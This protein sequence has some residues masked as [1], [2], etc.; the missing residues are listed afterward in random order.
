MKYET[1]EQCTLSAAESLLSSGDFNSL[2]K[3]IVSISLYEE[4]LVAAQNICSRVAELSHSAARGNAILGFG[5]LA[6]R[7]AFLD[8]NLVSPLIIN[9]LNDTDSY[10]RSQ[11]DA[12]ADDIEQFLGWRL[13]V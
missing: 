1:I 9:A 5:H 6:R 12:A 4:D 10:V 3:Q 11:A 7:S 8:K 13:R 2:A